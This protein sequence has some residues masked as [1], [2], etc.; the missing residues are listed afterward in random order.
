M[1]HFW[2]AY[3]W[4]S[5]KCHLSIAKKI[6]PEKLN[7][8][9]TIRVSSVPWRIEN[10]GSDI[11]SQLKNKSHDF[12]CSSLAL[13]QLIDVTDSTPLLLIW[14]VSVK[15]EVAEELV[16]TN[17]LHETTRGDNIFKE[18]ERINLAQ[19]A[20]ESPNRGYNWQWQKIPVEHQKN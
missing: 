3:C 17:S 19:T 8:F 7:V 6:C 5:T 9:E 10:V 1:A 11:S 18:V 12:E 14:E 16:S 4:S 13:D 2:V 15:L 20:V